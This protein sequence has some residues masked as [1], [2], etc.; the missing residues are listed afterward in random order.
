MSSTG[1]I[2]KNFQRMQTKH[3]K[4][5]VKT[6]SLGP[7][8]CSKRERPTSMDMA[9]WFSESIQREAAMIKWASLTGKV[10]ASAVMSASALSRRAI[11]VPMPDKSSR[12]SNDFVEK[13]FRY[14]VLLLIA[15]TAAASTILFGTFW[16]MIWLRG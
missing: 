6:T 4:R 9:R 10:D 5:R 3:F 8:W 15:L 12:L 2:Y 11:N 16:A 7:K 14:A 1:N 13:G